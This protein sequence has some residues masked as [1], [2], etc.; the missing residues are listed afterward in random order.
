MGEG[1]ADRS[2]K[3]CKDCFHFDACATWA[4]GFGFS[5]EDENCQYFKD[6]KYCLEVPCAVGDR[7]Y[8]IRNDV[9]R[10]R[11]AVICTVEAIHFGL[12][13]SGYM[14][15]RP[16]IQEWVGNRSISYKYALS[17]FGRN[18]FATSAEADEFLNKT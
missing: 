2:T 14:R 18:V 10:Y 1:M 5:E 7:V 9:G 12:G 16:L 15:L 6:K 11:A 8:A 17:S 3:R 13:G 4:E